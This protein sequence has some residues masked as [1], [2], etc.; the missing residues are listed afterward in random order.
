MCR[1]LEVALLPSGAHPVRCLPPRPEGAQGAPTAGP[2]PPPTLS[3][4]SAEPPSGTPIVSVSA[5]DQ[6][7][8]LAADQWAFQRSCSWSGQDW[9]VLAR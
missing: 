1:K 7:A 4:Q 3:G 2:D 9:A 8:P 5:S 6:P